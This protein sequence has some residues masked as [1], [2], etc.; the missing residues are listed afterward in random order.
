MRIALLRST[1]P[2]MPAP[3]HTKKVNYY[4]RRKRERPKLQMPTLSRL[5]CLP[6]IHLRFPS[7]QPT[8]DG[9]DDQSDI[10]KILS[11]RDATAADFQLGDGRCGSAQ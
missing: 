5:A 3:E 7:S 8:G 1:M 10:P 6:S 4:L 2:T 9:R 11:E